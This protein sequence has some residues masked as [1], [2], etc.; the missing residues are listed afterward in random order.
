MVY[1]I[2]SLHNPEIPKIAKQLRNEGLEVFDDWYAPGP[3]T[4]DYWQA[5]ENARGHTYQQALAGWH[6]QDV[7][8]FDKRHLDRALCAL[9]VLP[10]GKSGHLELG[11]VIGRGRPGFILLDKEPERFDVMYNFATMVSTDL[12]KLLRSIKQYDSTP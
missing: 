6:A 9:L 12:T 7:F 10:A 3:D 5:Y 11:Y 1:L 8:A 2:G 4:D